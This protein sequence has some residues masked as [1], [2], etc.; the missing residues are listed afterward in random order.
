MNIIYWKVDFITTGC[1]LLLIGLD[2]WFIV[3]SFGG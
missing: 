1:F 3:K 2:L